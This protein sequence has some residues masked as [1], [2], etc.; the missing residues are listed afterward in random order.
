MSAIRLTVQSP[1]RDTRVRLRSV[2]GQRLQ[3]VEEVQPDGE[4][5]L[6]P[7]LV[8]ILV[9]VLQGGVEAF[10]QVRPGQRVPLEQCL[11]AVGALQL[12]HGRLA[13]RRDGPV[14]PGVQGDHLLHGHLL[15]GI[16]GNREVFF[17]QSRLGPQLR[18][19]VA[20]LT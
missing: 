5:R 7:A 9:T 10:P 19:Y 8:T 13:R 1:R 12:G 14:A 2:Q 16:N 3:Q 6:R 11:K 15:T 4:R 17:D 20:G 18:P